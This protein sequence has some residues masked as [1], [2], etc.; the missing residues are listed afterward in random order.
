MNL[1][2]PQHSITSIKQK[3]QEIGKKYNN[4]TNEVIEKDLWI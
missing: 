3:L 4:M 2:V 1:N